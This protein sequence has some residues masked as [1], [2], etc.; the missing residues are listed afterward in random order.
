MLLTTH[1]TFRWNLIGHLP[2][3]P[4]AGERT[5]GYGYRQ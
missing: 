2:V 4:A 1:N 5:F 3:L